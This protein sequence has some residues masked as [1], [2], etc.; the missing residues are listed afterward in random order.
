GPTLEQKR[1]I[2]KAFQIRVKVWPT[3]MSPNWVLEGKLNQNALE[4]MVWATREDGEKDA[5]SSGNLVSG[6]GE[7][8]SHGTF[9]TPLDKY[10]AVSGTGESTTGRSVTS[11]LDIV[12]TVSSANPTEVDI[13]LAA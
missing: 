1:L 11:S 7:S 12:F 10:L 5:G 9:V 13:R 3:N 8:T 2:A 6:V 4:H